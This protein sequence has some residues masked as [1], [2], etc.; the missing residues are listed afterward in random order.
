MVIWLQTRWNFRNSHIHPDTPTT[1]TTIV[2]RY[3]WR[4]KT[5]T[6]NLWSCGK[7]SSSPSGRIFFVRFCTFGQ[8][9]KLSF[10]SICERI[11]GTFNVALRYFSSTKQR[12]KWNPCDWV[13]NACRQYNQ[14]KKILKSIRGIKNCDIS[15]F[16]AHQCQMLSIYFV[17][18]TLG[19]NFS[20]RFLFNQRRVGVS[21]NQKIFS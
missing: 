6:W 7:V 10:N 20:A 3:T 4:E 14:T 12:W 21:C 9:E 13:F 2:S 8:N 5:Q 17:G 11:F 16:I 15:N 1:F 19:D 18:A